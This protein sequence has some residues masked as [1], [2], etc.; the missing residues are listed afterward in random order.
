MLSAMRKCVCNALQSNG[1]ANFEHSSKS[2]F[3]PNQMCWIAIQL[4]CHSHIVVH[5]TMSECTR[6]LD[7]DYN[8]CIAIDSLCMQLSVV[9]MKSVFIPFFS[10]R[11]CTEFKGV[12]HVSFS[13]FWKFNHLFFPFDRLFICRIKHW[14]NGCHIFCLGLSASEKTIS[15]IQLCQSIEYLILTALAL[16]FRAM[17]VS[18]RADEN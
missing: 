17:E 6:N 1:A 9:E 11:C 12:F 10:F 2:V 13:S 8:L 4:T 3:W 14:E 18:W 5:I 16:S 15:E 7:I